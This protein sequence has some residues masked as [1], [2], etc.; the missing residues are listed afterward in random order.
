[1]FGRAGVGVVG[2]LGVALAQHLKN[3]IEP[4]RPLRLG[5]AQLAIAQIDDARLRPGDELHA[6]ALPAQTTHLEEIDM[7][8]KVRRPRRSGRAFDRLEKAL[9]VDW[10]RKNFGV[11]DLEPLGAKRIGGQKKA[12][13]LGKR[14]PNEPATVRPSAPSLSSCVRS[15]S[16]PVFCPAHA[17]AA[18]SVAT[19]SAV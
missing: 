9:A 17:M 10:F 13:R 11:G 7:V 15:R 2:K 14:S 5:M 6:A 19:K 16:H 8:K 18:S 1:M 3:R 12:W 4:A